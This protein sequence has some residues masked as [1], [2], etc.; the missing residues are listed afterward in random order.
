MNNKQNKAFTLVELLV[1]ITILSIISVVAYQNFGSAVNKAIS[2]RKIWD[3]ATIESSLAQ[4]KVTKNQYPS[5]GLYESTTNM[6]GYNSGATASASNTMDLAYT[7]QEITGINSADWGWVIYW[8]WS[9]SS[10]QIGAKGTISQEQLGKQYLST[11]L[12]DPEVW[13]LKNSWNN[14]ELI[15]SW[16]G[17]Y[18][19]AVYRKPKWRSWGANNYGWSYYNIAYT[20]KKDESDTYITK[21]VWDYD[22]ESCFDN[23]DNCNESLIWTSGAYLIDWQEQWYDS[24]A[25]ALN[26]FESS[27]ENQWIPYPVE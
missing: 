6:W 20:I 26:S 24:E 1:V 22:Q 10:N 17:R 2:W 7:D 27:D 18:V 23:S 8:T 15:E 19:Y 3:V 5:V 12:Y 11:D 21:I 14:Q 4:Y 16:L 13:E 25:N 9:W